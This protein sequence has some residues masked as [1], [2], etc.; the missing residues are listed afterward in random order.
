MD[1][2]VSSQ[3]TPGDDLTKPEAKPKEY[4]ANGHLVVKLGTTKVATLSELDGYQS[5]KADGMVGMA[6]TPAVILKLYALFG[7]KSLTVDGVLK[8]LPPTSNDMNVYRRAQLFSARELA[9]LMMA[10]A[11]EFMP[12]PESADDLKN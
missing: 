7:L 5:L 3:A 6:A 11:E 12:E 4:D 9:M 2:D 10:Y 1:I 8:T